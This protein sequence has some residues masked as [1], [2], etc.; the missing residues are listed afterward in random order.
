MDEIDNSL[1]LLPNGFIDLLPPF[2]E[3]EAIAVSLLME[4]FSSFGYSRIK[5]PLLEFE[6]SLLGA[7]IGSLLSGETFRLM[8]S[9]SNNMLAIR[10]DTTAQLSRIAFSRLKNQPRPLRLSYAND[11]LRT[12][13]SQM[14]IERQFVQVGCE[15]VGDGNNGFDGDVEI[16]VVAIL[17]LKSLGLKDITI[18]FTIPNFVNMMLGDRVD[19]TVIKAVKQR[20]IDILY[21]FD[22]N[23]VKAMEASGKASDALLFLKDIDFDCDL[24]IRVEYLENIFKKVS[25]ALEQL[26]IDD[27]SITI[28]ILEQAGFEYHKGFGFT[29]FSRD[30]YGEIGRGGSYDMC[31]N[32]NGGFT[33]NARGFTLYMDTILKA[34][35]ISVEKKV[36]FVSNDERWDIISKLQS[37]GWV[38]IRGRSPSIDCTHIYE[39]GKVR[40]IN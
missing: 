4:V 27:V 34:V 33:E 31:F 8:D 22:S 15:F 38:V 25:V 40:E 5:P 21:S 1:S 6:D 32:D 16:C 23:L 39:N 29:I 14:R 11:V 24:R 10:S 30:A 28:D 20:D 3:R 2:A 19:D 7:G 17:A 18:D 37:E 35:D 36:L 9:I 26:S 13:G 12:Y